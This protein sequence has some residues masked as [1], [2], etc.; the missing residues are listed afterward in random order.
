MDTSDLLT[1]L[2][3]WLRPSRASLAVDLTKALYR[4]CFGG[5]ILY[6]HSVHK[7]RSALAHL[8][9]GKRW[10]LESEVAAI[11]MPWPFAGLAMRPVAALL[12]AALGVA[13]CQNIP[14]RSEPQL[15]ALYS[16]G[17]AT[18]ALW[19]GGEFSFKAFLWLPTGGPRP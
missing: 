13:I 3:A 17:V 2:N 6:F 12:T 4:V 11:H 15:A 9:S 10:P 1:L 19:G 8:R 5:S 14:T 18:L 7:L 16:L